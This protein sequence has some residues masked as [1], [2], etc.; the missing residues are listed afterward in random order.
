MGT[1]HGYGTWVQCACTTVPHQCTNDYQRTVYIGDIH[2]VRVWC[3]ATV[4]SDKSATRKNEHSKLLPK[5]MN[6]KTTQRLAGNVRNQ[7]R[8]H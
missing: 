7:V 1:V 4:Q 3:M 8:N 5:K 2:K 6:G